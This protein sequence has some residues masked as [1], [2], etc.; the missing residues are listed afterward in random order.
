MSR[1]PRTFAALLCSVLLSQIAVLQAQIPRGEREPRL[2]RTPPA[3]PIPRDDVYFPAHPW[4][5]VRTATGTVTDPGPLEVTAVCQGGEKL[6]GGGYVL[7]RPPLSAGTAE[8]SPLIIE[9][10]YPAGSDRWTVVAN[11]PNTEADEFTFGVAVRVEAYCLTKP[12]AV[13]Q[14]VSSP[15]VAVE[16]NA[17]PVPIDATCPSGSFVTAGGYRT[18]HTVRHAGLYNS[19]VWG[20]APIMTQQQAVGWRVESNLISWQVEPVPL[21]TTTAYAICARP[22]LVGSVCLPGRRGG[23]ERCGPGTIRAGTAV[24]GV[25]PPVD[26]FGYTYYEGDIS[27]SADEVT[28]GGG[29]QF[30]GD[31][32]EQYWIPHNIYRTGLSDPFS[33]VWGIGGVAGFQTARYGGT[34]VGGITAYATC[35]KLPAVYLTVRI[36][37]PADRSSPE[38]ASTGAGGGPADKTDFI[39]FAAIAGDGTGA[40][41]SDAT[42]EWTVDGDPLGTGETVTASLPASQCTIVDRRIQVT[43]TDSAGH[44]ATDA[45]TLYVGGVC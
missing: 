15:T 9:A 37:S 42:F 36:L 27:C 18:S 6:L 39:T 13:I 4:L 2:P 41:V 31:T 30:V 38:L 33:G 29:Y 5:V 26:P 3:A 44:T 32:V 22:S 35:I 43:A 7:P 19:W 11:N 21:P 1:C 10:S 12:I 16:F 24:S 28:V 20:S 34:G 14:I 23:L 8:N 40:L 25:A 17:D 45:I